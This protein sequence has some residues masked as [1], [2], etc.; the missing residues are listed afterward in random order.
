M[1]KISLLFPGVLLAFACQAQSIVWSKNFGGSG[2]EGTTTSRLTIDGG[3]IS[4]G[5]TLSTDGNVSGSHGGQDAWVV[6]LNSVGTL[7]WQKCLGGTNSDYATGVLQTSDGGFMI[8]GYTNS[9]NGDFADNHG[10][11]DAFAVKLDATGN[12]TWKKCYGDSYNQLS[13]DIAPAHDGGFVLAG[14]CTF[15]TSGYDRDWITKISAAGIQDW[16]FAQLAVNNAQS[17]GI[18]NIEPTADSGFICAGD[19]GVF[20]AGGE[21]QLLKLRANGTMQWVKN[22]GSSYNEY[23]SRVNIT[24]DGNYLITGAAFNPTN[25]PLQVGH[26]GRYDYWVLKTDTAGTVIWKKFFGG[27]LNEY[28][29]D[30]VPTADGG[31]IVLGYAESN[32]S[33]VSGMRTPRDAWM[34]KLS[35]TGNLEWQ[36][37]YGGPGYDAG[38]GITAISADELLLSGTGGA[39]GDHITSNNGSSDFWIWKVKLHPL[40]DLVMNSYSI[41]GSIATGSNFTAQFSASNLGPGPA[42]PTK[43]SF[44]FSADSVFTP[45]KNGDSLIGV[46]PLTTVVT[47]GASS[48]V[49][50]H[51]MFMPCM[52]GPGNYYLAIVADGLRELPET[53]DTNNAVLVPFTLTTGLTNPVPIIASNQPSDS[54]CIS[55]V[56]Q[57]SVANSSACSTCSYQWNTASTG[58]AISVSS[59]SSG[60]YNYMVYATNA[61]GTRTATKTIYYASIPTVTATAN[62]TAV[63][64][65]DSVT[66]SASGA[67]TYKWTGRGLAVSMGSIVRAGTMSAGNTVF[68]VSGGRQGCIRS[69]TVTVQVN[70]CTANMVYTFTGNGN[71]NQPSNW[72]NNLVPP[73]II[74][75]GSEVIIDPA[76]QGECLVTGNITFAPGAKFTIRPGNTIRVAANI[77]VL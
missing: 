62:P 26:N 6:K 17:S 72:E 53:N 35:A 11:Y 66:L 59:S 71:W 1:K 69:N 4:V 24:P 5:S 52:S 74:P 2:S 32:D 43:V 3:S 44:Y 14:H 39:V 47:G 25:S 55:T 8:T 7:L 9:W 63:C 48:V 41:P 73:N 16:T 22:Y 65:G 42:D 21:G 57:L 46:S 30:A 23:F 75:N 77:A 54:L 10:S 36:R 31:Y 64:A 61:C 15:S 18:Q 76:G 28:G 50:S 49:A 68:T 34:L 33:L 13:F 51:T 20:F 29:T 60:T 56:V 45:G 67:T 12:I 38:A 19:A 70:T 27:S 37:T 40:P 58:T